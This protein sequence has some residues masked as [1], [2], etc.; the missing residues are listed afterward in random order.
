MATRKSSTPRPDLAELIT[1]VLEH[2]D[3]PGKLYDY[4]IDGLMNLDQSLRVYHVPEYTRAVL[5]E[6]RD[7][8]RRNSRQRK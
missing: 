4:V 6:N 7:Y 5:K 2:P 3:T 1:Q 8:Q